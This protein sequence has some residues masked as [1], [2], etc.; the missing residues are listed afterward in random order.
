M[1]VIILL[2]KMSKI[3][4]SGLLSIIILG[5]LS[6]IYLNTSV[7]GQLINSNDSVPAKA[8][9]IQD[10]VTSNVP[11]RKVHVGD[12]DIGY[13]IFGKDYPILLITGAN[14]VRMDVWDPV[15]LREL[16]SNNTVIIFD[17][18]GVGNTT[19]GFK[20]FSIKQFAN[21]T[22]G[23][24]DALNIKKPVDVLGWSMGSFIAQELAILHPEKVNKLILYA[25][26][27]S[28][29][30]SVPPSPKVTTF[31]TKNV[32]RITSNGNARFLASASLLF[33]KTWIKENPNYL[34]YLPKSKESASIQT[35]L[36]QIRAMSTW[37]D[38]CDQLSRITK[39]TLVIDGT[40][41]IIT[42]S[43]NSLLIAEKIPGAW[44]VRINGAGHGLMYQY[45][46]KFSK[47]VKTFLEEG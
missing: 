12:I 32:T 15:L 30:Q 17:N 13:K 45:P 2:F 38:S 19:S 11:T 7:L 1:V 41:D 10:S 33:P 21:D 9:T 22:S 47:I 6:I 34:Q 27:C 4:S 40:S 28:G 8:T 37:T 46:Q 39:P 23:L 29:K 26:S 20:V 16:A 36:G 14:G 42:P 3:I 5:T 25:S 43:A 24:L 31:F 35:I 44:L 18:R